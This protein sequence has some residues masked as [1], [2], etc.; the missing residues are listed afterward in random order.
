MD[1]TT[2]KAIFNKW[3]WTV[4]SVAFLLTIGFLWYR[5]T[6]LLIYPDGTPMPVERSIAV[7][8][9]KDSSSEGNQKYLGYGAAEGILR[10]LSRVRSLK[11]SGKSSSFYFD[12]EKVDLNEIK[13][14]LDINTILKG[15]IHRNNDQLHLTAELIRVDDGFQIWTTN[16]E[17]SFND[18]TKVQ[19]E[20][21]RS[22]VKQLKLEWPKNSRSPASGGL[23]ANMEA[24]DR[25]LRANYQQSRQT[26]ERLAN[27]S[28]LY[29]AAIQL[30][31]QFAAAYVGKA[32][33]LTRQALG[34]Q[35]VPDS[36]K[37]QVYTFLEQALTLDPENGQAQILLGWWKYAH[38]WDFEAG[39][40]HFNKA[41]ALRNPSVTTM[42]LE[43]LYQ[44]GQFEK[45]FR[46]ITQLEHTDPLSVPVAMTKGLYYFSKGRFDRSAQSLE[47][48]LQLDPDLADGYAKLGKVH[49]NSGQADKA[50]K[51]LEKG[52]EMAAF[53]SPAI[54]SDL[55]IAYHQQGDKNKM[56]QLLSELEQMHR[57]RRV[58]LSPAFYTAQVYSSLGEKELAFEWLGKAFDDR[59]TKVV[60]LGIEPQMKSLQNDSRY[61]EMMSRLGEIVN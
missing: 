1:L 53:R 18:L 17:R 7:L 29:G 21:A 52:L 19:V 56:Q 24:Y 26:P 58:G 54:M 43:P 41:S 8:P 49:L 12:N 55:A 30:D 5:Y 32:A 45:A 25:F 44:T 28:E 50:I 6:R 39:S 27:A 59:E 13:E 51:V 47:Y 16:E 23:P 42:L 11:V 35:L 4:G 33:V 37:N 46:M 9:F 3:I 61:Q 14:A 57:N 36:V 31:P 38:E 60:W 40:R 10:T 48:A 15:T 34:G 22:V 20:I 2:P